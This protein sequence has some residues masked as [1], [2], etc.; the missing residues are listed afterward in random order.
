MFILKQRLIYK[1][2]TLGKPVYLVPEHF[3]TKTCS[4]CGN[5]NQYVGSSEIF[6]CNTCNFIAGRDVNAAKNIKMKGLLL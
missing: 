2:G 4:S 3:T 1:A 6:T 5:I